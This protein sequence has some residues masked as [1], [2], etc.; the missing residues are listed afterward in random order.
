MNKNSRTVPINPKNLAEVS[1]IRPILIVLLVVYHAFIIYRGGVGSTVWF[2][3]KC[4]VLV[5]SCYLI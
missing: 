3:G 2:P 1:I 4:S 5:D